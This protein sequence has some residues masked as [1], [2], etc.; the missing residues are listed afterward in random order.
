MKTVNIGVISGKR[1]ST[2][3]ARMASHERRV[4]LIV[5]IVFS[6]LTARVVLVVSLLLMGIQSLLSNAT[7]S[8]KGRERKEKKRKLETNTARGS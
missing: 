2:L 8:N 7:P 3:R 4:A 5:L 1:W 6:E